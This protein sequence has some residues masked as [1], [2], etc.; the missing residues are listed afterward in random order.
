MGE[1]AVVEEGVDEQREVVIL[2]GIVEVV[3]QLEVAE[4]CDESGFSF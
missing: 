3:E 1:V 4:E 2:G